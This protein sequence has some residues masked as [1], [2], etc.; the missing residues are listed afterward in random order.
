[1]PISPGLQP[2]RRLEREIGQHAVGAGAL[3]G[4][5]ALQH[6]RVAV[7]P[8]VAGGGRDHRVLAADTW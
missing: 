7:E 1:M 3:E 2:P 6:R 4:E 5:Q 8:A